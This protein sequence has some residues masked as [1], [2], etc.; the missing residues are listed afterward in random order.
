MAGL[1]K[2]YIIEILLYSEASNLIK[3]LWMHCCRAMVSFFLLFNGIL[4]WDRD[5]PINGFLQILYSSRA[6]YSRRWDEWSA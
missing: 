2:S 4:L 1:T 3:Y 6:K 5:L